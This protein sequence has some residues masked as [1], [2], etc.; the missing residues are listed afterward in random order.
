MND[1]ERKQKVVEHWE[2][3]IEWMEKNKKKDRYYYF[4]EDEMF[5]EL[6][7]NATH[8]YCEFCKKYLD[9]GKFPFNP[10]GKCPIALKFGT[11]NE[12]NGYP[13]KE[14]VRDV[15]LPRA[16]KFL[17]AIKSLEVGG[18]PKNTPIDWTKPIRNK[19]T[20]EDVIEITDVKKVR[21]KS[22]VIIVD[23]TGKGA[24]SEKQKVENVKEECYEPVRIGDRVTICGEEYMFVSAGRNLIIL[25][26]TRTGDR[27]N[28][29]PI[30]Q[31]DYFF[32]ISL[33]EFKELTS[34]VE[35]N[36]VY[37]TLKRRI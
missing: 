29:V 6:G 32:Y 8:V 30:K 20:G 28:D 13:G 9:S 7:E 36:E 14:G 16:R 34:L 19:E 25:I 31:R 2:R 5:N 10:C 37:K 35:W 26:N 4:D 17:E 33:E 11:C 12:L 24:F 15:W 22:K 18:E 21:T 1:F 23:L 3:M 27:W